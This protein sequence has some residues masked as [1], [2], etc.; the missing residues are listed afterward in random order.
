VPLPEEAQQERLRTPP[1]RV[2]DG[3]GQPFGFFPFGLLR[4]DRPGDCLRRPTGGR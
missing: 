2:C 4:F 1:R 3:A